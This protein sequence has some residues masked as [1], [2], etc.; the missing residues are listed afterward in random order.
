MI[1]LGLLAAAAGAWILWATRRERI[2][3][4]RWIL[5]AAMLLPLMPLFA[6]SFGWIFTEMGRQPWAVF[7]LMTTATAVSPGV[8]VTEA[9][10]SV[11]TLTLVYAVL[12]VIEISLM[13]KF[14]RKGADEFVEPPSPTLRGDQ[15]DEPLTFAY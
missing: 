15:A 2:P 5:W 11:V 8:S 14:I 10:I 12:A 9:M 4:G 6:N 1:G 3:A 13:I 7:G